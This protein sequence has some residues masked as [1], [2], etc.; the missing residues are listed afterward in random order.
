MYTC[1]PPETLLFQRYRVVQMAGQ[2]AFG[3]TYLVHD[4][5]RFNELCW[6]QEFVPAQ[7]NPAQP[8]A[9]L[10]ESLRQR[11]H[12]EAALLYELQHPQLPRFRVMVAGGDRLYLVRDYI[13][14]TP[15]SSLWVERQATGQVFSQAEV[16]Q[17][18]LHLLPVLTYLHGLGMVHQA[19]CP[20][21]IIQRRSDLQ[22]VLV[23]FGLVRQWVV[24]LG[25]HPVPHDQAIATPEFAAPEQHNLEP[26]FPSTDLYG[27]GATAI[28]LLT[29]QQPQQLANRWSR[30]MQ[31]EKHANVQPDFAHVLNH[32]VHPNPHR[33][34][35]SA[36]QA[37][38]DLEAI[39]PLLFQ[40]DWGG[41]VSATSVPATS[42]STTSVPAASGQ[43]TSA[44]APAPG[45][46]SAP[47]N[48]AVGAQT[49]SYGGA[50]ATLT[51]GVRPIPPQGLK[52]LRSRPPRAPSK[53]PAVPA[54]FGLGRSLLAQLSWD[55]RGS[56]MLISSVALLVAA[57]AW[58]AMSWVQPDSATGPVASNVANPAISRSTG[59]AESLAPSSEL[60][61]GS[62]PEV[63]NG[64]PAALAPPT[65]SP[66]PA[67]PEAPLV[68]MPTRESG[69]AA[70]MPN[71]PTPNQ[72]QAGGKATPMQQLSDRRQ[73][74][75]IESAFL[76]SLT[77]EVFYAKHPDLQGE[78]LS[79]DAA[80]D[81][82]RSEWIAIANDLLT[83]LE[84]LPNSSRTQLGSYR[85]NQY[86]RW[87]TPGSGA[88]LNQ[89]E[90]N[91]LVNN[92][93]GQ[94]FPEQKDKTLNPKTFGQV[95]YA[96]AE[97]ELTNL[98]P[99]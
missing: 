89:Q 22:P 31:W 39:A 15:Y 69:S 32:L 80:Q 84:T 11:F 16:M 36:L 9:A 55:W 38:R 42:V 19:I 8:S 85:R 79:A 4:Q 62:T 33:R 74:A 94:L 21:S 56:A 50:K 17:L 54:R 98:K 24:Q 28:A 71:S 57:A 66:L 91:V 43:P 7:S 47:S 26:V 52:P 60:P 5:K 82:L 35:E 63:A 75:G 90:L 10:L 67:S 77:D 92:R 53:N 46:V 25:L 40:T 1:L 29:G 93:F 95:W 64:A 96:I 58:K 61:L 3:F 87:M 27:L 81:A 18:L 41:M 51:N 68:A 37:R 44:P 30:S 45:V 88:S 65:G 6:M 97:S 76:L 73:Q 59:Q 99:Q 86:D 13:L 70:T 23:G 48:T 14:G 20:S 34:Y 72:P 78:K 83:Q 12:Q 49:H 2:D